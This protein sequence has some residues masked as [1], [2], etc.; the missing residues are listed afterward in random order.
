[1]PRLRV[2]VRKLA[3]RIF[4]ICLRT[5]LDLMVISGKNLTTN[6]M[7]GDDWQKKGREY[8]PAQCVIHPNWCKV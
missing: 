8:N 7:K 6:F 4:V 2:K 3:R 5:D 1:M